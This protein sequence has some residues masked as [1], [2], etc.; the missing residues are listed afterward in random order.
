M[1]Q[2][3]YNHGECMLLMTFTANRMLVASLH[4]HMAR[5]GLELTT[6]QWG[7]LTLFGNSGDITQEEMTR[8]ACVDKST[9]SRAVGAMERKGWITRRRD[10]ADTRRKILTLANEADVLKHGSLE[11]VQATLKH[12]LRGIDSE[13]RATCLKVLRQVKKNLQDTYP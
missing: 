12:A 1:A 10:S 11:A 7:L 6:E 4:K 5:L 8:C 3:L 13:D 2:D 9:V